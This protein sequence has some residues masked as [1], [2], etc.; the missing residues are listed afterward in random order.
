MGKKAKFIIS[1]L[2]LGAGRFEEGNLLEDFQSDDAFARFL[3]Q[4]AAEGQQ[5]GMA[6]ELIVAGDMFEFLQVPAL[7]TEEF[8]PLA[9][10]PVELYAS[11]DVAASCR[12]VQLII[13]GHPKIFAALC[14]FI[15]A[16]PPR[17][18]LTIIKGNHDVVLHWLA[19]QEAIRQAIGATGERAPC[20]TFEER[21]ISR[22]GIYVEHGNQYAEQVN[23][24][25]DFEEP[26][27]PDSPDQLYLPMGS[28]F[29]CVMF[30]DLERQLYWVDGIKPLTALVW[31]VFALDIGLAVR[32]LWTLLR[33][34]P[35]LVW[36][37]FA[38]K[39]TAKADLEEY[40]ALLRELEDDRV[41][42]SL[43]RRPRWRD[44]FFQR[45]DAATSYFG[46]PWPGKEQGLPRGPVRMVLSKGWNEE[47]CQHLSLTRV[48]DQRRMQERA[49]VVVFGH[50][51]QAGVEEFE[52]GAVY[53]N[54]GTWTWCRDFSGKDLAAWKRLLR[55]P[56]RYASQRRLNYVRVDYADDGTPLGR[57]E[58]FRDPEHPQP[59]RSLWRRLSGR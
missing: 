42:E 27:D 59:P 56:E 29:V 39:R 22:E 6:L 10:Y 40:A 15:Q 36:D 20:L 13:A 28:R 37:S 43:Q 11:S 55:H 2:H 47:Y 9:S 57:L 25:P 48:A 1:D 34:A 44:G 8:D 31:Y 51:H 19:V 14:D 30:N 12:K 26:H 45:V 49:R 21:R 54:S 24:F 3:G 7:A 23:R 5:Q 41:L 53:I 4:I 18:T 32:V 16:S 46:A 33:Q 50:T 58:E 17:R 38:I 52:D 35:A